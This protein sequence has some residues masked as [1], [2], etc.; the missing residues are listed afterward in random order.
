MAVENTSETSENSKESFDQLI[1]REGEICGDSGSLY[2]ELND[3]NGSFCNRQFA[4]VLLKNG[5]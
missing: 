1:E 4:F 3:S 5:K 2:A